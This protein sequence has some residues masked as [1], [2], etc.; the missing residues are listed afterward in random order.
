MS[1]SFEMSAPA[2]L[3]NLVLRKKQSFGIS[4]NSKV[5][6]AGEGKSRGTLML[7]LKLGGWYSL[8]PE[9]TLAFRVQIYNH[10]T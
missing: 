7:G 4:P 6:L 9:S 1:H 3:E 5:L 8:P 10:R 2:P